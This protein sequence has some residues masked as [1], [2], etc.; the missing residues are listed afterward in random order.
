M[1]EAKEMKGK[2]SVKDERNF[3]N[4]HYN[5][6]NK[7]ILFYLRYSLAYAHFLP[8]SP[9]SSPILVVRIRVYNPYHGTIQ[10]QHYA[11]A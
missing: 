11:R 7:Y 2:N 4:D 10:F 9:S 8:S 6:P 1:N 5:E 3:P